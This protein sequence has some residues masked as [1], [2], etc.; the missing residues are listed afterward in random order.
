M[1]IL[2]IFTSL[3]WN[4]LFLVEQSYWDFTTLIIGVVVLP[5]TF[6]I[7]ILHQIEDHGSSLRH[8]QFIGLLSSMGHFYIKLW[9][10]VFRIDWWFI[11]TNLL[12]KGFNLFPLDRM[13]ALCKANK[14]ILLASQWW[15]DLFI[16][17]ANIY[18]K[19]WQVWC[20]THLNISSPLRHFSLLF[21]FRFKAWIYFSR[22]KVNECFGCG[23]GGG[24]PHC[25]L[26]NSSI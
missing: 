21:Y 26:G 20:W 5:S 2:H 25:P 8:I 10:N 7:I 3:R 6:S 11:A 22:A 18:Q 4:R 24:V 9:A 16:R 1:A 23:H 19:L 15:Y 12:V 14:I 17:K 13:E